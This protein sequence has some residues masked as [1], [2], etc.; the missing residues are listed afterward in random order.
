MNKIAFFVFVV[1]SLGF[2]SMKQFP[3]FN[4]KSYGGRQ[5]SEKNL[6]G[7]KTIVVMGHIECL[8][9]VLI[10]KDL[11]SLCQRIDTSKVQVLAILE[12]T[13][14]HID[15]FY[16]DT[17]NIWGKI[18]YQ[19][20]VDTL[21]FPII[22]ECHSEKVKTRKGQVKIGNHCRKLSRKVRTRSSPTVLLINEQK[23]KFKRGFGSVQR[24]RF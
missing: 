17:S 3:E 9:L 20:G 13:N 6:K 19:F 7:K 1:F 15:Q 16:G 10:L 4:S 12:N 22:A 18:R 8:P 11:D 2:A 14:S 21:R 24:L 5:F 23:I